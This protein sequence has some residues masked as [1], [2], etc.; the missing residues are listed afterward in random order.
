MG[1]V[2]NCVQTEF[3]QYPDSVMSKLVSGLV[4]MFVEM[5][6]DIMVG[7]RENHYDDFSWRVNC[8]MT[9]DIVVIS[10]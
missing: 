2:N 4:G 9:V 5:R 6:V 1:E 3:R 8:K 10:L 7:M